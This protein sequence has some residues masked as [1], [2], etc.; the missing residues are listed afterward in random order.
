MAEDV[1]SLTPQHDTPPSS[2]G[3]Q[4]RRIDSMCGPY[5]LWQIARAFGK[6]YS[7]NSIMKMADTSAIEGTTIDAM[8]RTIR[9][10]GLFA[11]PV[12]TRIGALAQ[13]PSVA[14]LLLHYDNCRHYVILD[15]VEED[16]IRVLDGSE[17]RDITLQEL[18][19]LWR[20]HAML[21]SNKDQPTVASTQR[22]LGVGLQVLGGLIVLA[23]I[24]FSGSGRRLVI[25]L[26][27][28]KQP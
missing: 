15:K 6:D 20:G 28:R 1:A 18:K 10:I 2:C 23:V 25:G 19:S 4:T 16:Y 27:I 5:C 22:R 7:V 26:Q 3:S 21:I 14:I 8:V 9:E 17:F 24:A 12:K 13:D 11:V